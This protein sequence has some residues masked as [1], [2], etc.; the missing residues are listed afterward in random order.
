[1]VKTDK[2][3]RRDNVKRDFKERQDQSKLLIDLLKKENDRKI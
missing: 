3:Q 2:M 1:M